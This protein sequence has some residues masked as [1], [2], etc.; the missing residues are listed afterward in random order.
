MIRPIINSPTVLRKDIIE[1]AVQSIKE[2]FPIKT[3]LGSLEVEDVRVVDKEYSLKD[4]KAAKIAREHLTIPIKGRV[5]LKDKDGNV[6]DESTRTIVKVPY[7]TGRHSFIFG[8]N[9]YTYGN[10][11]RMKPGVLLYK[12]GADDIRAMFNLEKGR[13]F[14]LEF[15]PDTGKF[16]IRYG[17]KGVPLFAALHAL[18][19]DPSQLK[20]I[21]GNDLYERNKIKDI[22]K[23]IETLY[24]Q[25]YPDFMRQHD[26]IEAKKQAIKEHLLGSVMDPIV[27]K[28]T[29]GVEHSNLTPEVFINAVKKLIDLNKS[30]VDIYDDRDNIGYKKLFGVDDFIAER[31]KHITKDI[32]SR[33]NKHITTNPSIS[34]IMPSWYMTDSLIN[35]LQM[36]ELSKISEQYNPLSIIDERG[37]ISLMGEGGIGDERAIPIGA[38]QVHGSHLG[39]VDP[40]KTSE[41]HHAGVELR[42]TITAAK[43]EKGNLYALLLDK[44]GNK[45]YVPNIEFVNK[46]IA[47]YP[48]RKG[49]KEVDALVKGLPSRVS[50][51]K[52]DYILPSQAFLYGEVTNLIPFKNSVD[53]NRALMGAKHITQA[54][55]LKDP[56][57]L[58]VRPAMKGKDL[59]KMIAEILN[60]RSPVDGVVTGI[61]SDYIYIKPLKKQAASS[62]NI[63]K[64]PHVKNFPL[65]EGAFFS[66]YP[67]VKP[68]D[69][70]KAGQVVAEYHSAR[71]GEI[72]VGKNLR[73]A[74]INY[75]G[76]NSNDAVVVSESAAKKLTSIHVHNVIVPKNPNSVFDKNKYIGKFMNKH[77]LET[78]K[79]LD[80]NGVIK[81]G[82]I[83]NPGEP[84]AVSMEP[85]TL[86][87]EAQFMGKLTRK[88]F[89]SHVDTSVLWDKNFPAEVLDVKETPTH[90]SITLR[91]EAP[92]QIGDKVSG[93][94]GNKGTIAKIIPDEQMLRTEDGQPLEILMTPAGV[95][96]RI[97]PAQLYEAALG[98]IASKTGKKYLIDI[99]EHIDNYKFVMDELKKHG[100]KSKETLIDPVT[101]KKIH[102]IFTGVS[103]ILKLFKTTDTN[104]SS[105]GIGHYD[106]NDQPVQGG[107]A[108]AKAIGKMEFDALLSHNVKNLLNDIIIKGNR[109]DEFWRAVQLGLPYP[110]HKTP[111]SFNRFTHFLNGL[112]V[113]VDKKSNIYYFLPMTTKEIE[114]ISAGEIKNPL[115]LNQKNLSPEEG[116]L[117]DYNLTGGPSGG[118]FAHITLHTPVLNPIFEDGV[119]DLLNLTQ[120]EFNDITTEKGFAG[121]RKL[122]KDFDYNKR[123]KEIL[124]K[125]ENKEELTSKD[126]SALK[127][128]KAMREHDIHPATHWFIEK[129]PVIPPISRPIIQAKDGKVFVSPFNYLYRDIIIANE[130]LKNSEDL[131]NKDK[132]IAQQTLYSAVKAL[133]G[134]DEPV[135]LQAKT[136]GAKG[137]I[138]FLGGTNPKAGYFQSVVLYKPQVLSAR[139]TAVPDTSLHMDN[140]RVPEDILW[141]IYQPF[142]VKRMLNKGYDAVTAK[143]MIEEKHPVAR[144]ALLL[145]C[146][147]RP[148]IYNRAPSLHRFNLVA[149]YPIPSQGKTIQ[150]S[151]FIEGGMNL[152]YDGDALQIHVPVTERGVEDAKK[153][154]PSKLIFGDRKKGDLMMIPGHEALWGAYVASKEKNHGGKKIVKFKTLDEAVEAWKRGEI[155]LGTE[156]VI[157]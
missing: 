53:P 46:V 2:N 72:K 78:L 60:P 31:I 28:Y 23:H 103:H 104:F 110:A 88:L 59:H 5:I 144:E 56:E 58:L 112:G 74:Y 83:V 40:I 124:E 136:K 25:L 114:K 43:D 116:G 12:H 64:I 34:T 100:I 153:I 126:I 55:Q 21:I 68:K 131:P 8:G 65:N 70:V 155:E 36:S 39:V 20:S 94:Y 6:L 142:L 62:D 151:P 156:V 130:N 92:A 71:D 120:K 146:K 97:N 29:I 27:N 119:K 4:E 7:L 33:L 107:E 81:R 141:N 10:M 57:P 90:Y 61:D 35:F 18:D 122:L 115:M 41:S 51:D 137:I 102:N 108:G 11:L 38:R 66:I 140:V 121:L 48:P 99:D 127:I 80:E 69:K 1:K 87:A 19:Y 129:L 157:G 123:E 145:E 128:I 118:K 132:L 54:L 15:S 3:N 14:N 13:N 9:E 109:N 63:V 49:E 84:I 91:M 117:F 37:R 22:D 134:L 98:K 152:D 17:T 93:L 73:S 50:V 77:P 30:G 135:S 26:T 149:G 79:K 45:T 89:N 85:S 82:A 148:I 42:S 16:T 111:T 113:K 139:G 86:T 52:I 105:V 67:A 147:E 24:E 106:Q 133:I 95:V 150:V 101:G 138:T 75:Y 143:K 76:L 125:V 96:S 154:L 47:F 44:K 32:A